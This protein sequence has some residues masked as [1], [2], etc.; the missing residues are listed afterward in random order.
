MGWQAKASPDAAA[1]EVTVLHLPARQKQLLSDVKQLPSVVDAYAVPMKKRSLP[2][3]DAFHP[4]SG[5]MF[6]CTVSKE[7]DLSA[8]IFEMMEQLDSS[9][10]P[11]IYV[12]VPTKDTFAAWTHEMAVPELPE[13]ASDE[14]KQHRT[15]LKHYVLL[16]EAVN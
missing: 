13:S 4:S 6:Q 10:S 5:R 11:A 2:G 8:G 16:L 15:N 7:H 1:K 14:V 3:I 9:V 12:V